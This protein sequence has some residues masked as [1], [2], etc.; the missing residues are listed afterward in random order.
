MLAAAPL[1]TLVGAGGVGKT[2]LA[3]ELVRAHLRR[4]TPT[5]RWLVELAGLTDASLLP[6]PSPPRSDCATSRRA[7]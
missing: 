2:R 5:A 3:Q 1:L 7:T 4:A 6:A